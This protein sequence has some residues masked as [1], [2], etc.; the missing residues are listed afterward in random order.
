MVSSVV[1]NTDIHVLL[2]WPFWPQGKHLPL[3]PPWQQ[4]AQMEGYLWPS[5]FVP[6]S[7]EGP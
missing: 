1:L 3:Q 4:S 7:W 6:C 5:Q 2:Q